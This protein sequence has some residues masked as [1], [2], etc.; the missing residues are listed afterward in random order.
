LPDEELLGREIGFFIP[1]T[2]KLWTNSPEEWCVGVRKH[3][4]LS[5]IHAFHLGLAGRNH[6]ELLLDKLR[7]SRK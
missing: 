3:C 2:D 1:P 5:A 6:P 4:W 7:N